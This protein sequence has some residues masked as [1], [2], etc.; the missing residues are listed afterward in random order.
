[1]NIDKLTDI[2]TTIAAVLTAAVVAITI[3][4]IKG[5]TI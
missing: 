1:M 4:I 3:Y 2:L 5:G